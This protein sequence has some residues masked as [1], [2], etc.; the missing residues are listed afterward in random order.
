MPVGM[1]AL[2]ASSAPQ[3]VTPAAPPA[4]EARSACRAGQVEAGYAGNSGNTGGDRAATVI[5]RNTGRAACL[6]PVRPGLAFLDIDRRS[7]AGL[8]TTTVSTGAVLPR[9]GRDGQEALD[10]AYSVIIDDLRDPCMP[11]RTLTPQ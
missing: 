10:I 8:P 9:P 4:S 1:P 6:L 3:G 7:I 2:D 11:A 5:F